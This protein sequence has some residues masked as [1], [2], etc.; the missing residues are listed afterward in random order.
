[1]TTRTMEAAAVGGALF[2]TTA[3]IEDLGGASVARLSITGAAL[4]AAAACDLA[5][6]RIPNRVTVP[7]AL[8]LLVLMAATGT[9][10][11]RIAG[12]LAVVGLLLGIGLVRPA[13]IGMGDTKLAL[14]VALGLTDKALTG[15][16]SGFVLAAIFASERIARGS[17]SRG[18]AIPLG[19]FLA[20]G[21]LIA[22]LA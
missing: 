14:V 18:T 20:L 13:A 7:A 4:A 16:A 2:S 15:M 8:A 21:A 10:F 19:P 5:E 3:L 6:R 17:S 1:M 11:G 22:L 9:G 12:G